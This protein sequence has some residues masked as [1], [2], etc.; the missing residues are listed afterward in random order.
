MSAEPINLDAAQALADAAT[1]GPWKWEKAGHGDPMLISG[2]DDVLFAYP[3]HDG[4]LE[5]DV[6]ESVDLHVQPDDAEFIAQARTLVPALVAELREL[7]SHESRTSDLVEETASLA[8]TAKR[9]TAESEELSNRCHAVADDNERLEA[10]IA[11]WKLRAEKA[12]STLA[13]LM[14]DLGKVLT[15]LRAQ[16]DGIGT[17]DDGHEWL[18]HAENLVQKAYAKAV[19]DA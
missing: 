3:V 8:K 5:D 19:R 4:P 15:N 18:C 14:T 7:Q 11:N 1:P 13:E 6:I 2:A 9:L 10:D 12:E 17:F 16:A